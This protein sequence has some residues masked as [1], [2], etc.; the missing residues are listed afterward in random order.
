MTQ[1]KVP[2]NWDNGLLEGLDAA[3]IENAD[4]SLFGMLPSHIAGGGRPSAALKPVEPDTATAY[5]QSA[6][7]LG[8]SFNYLFNA[9]CIDGLEFTKEWRDAFVKHLDWAVES[10]A[11]EITVAIPYILEVAHKR[12]PSLKI[13][14]SS[15]AR[16]HSVQR[17]RHF[18]ELGASEII[19]DPIT[20]ARDFKAIKAIASSVKADCSLI[21]N[22]M[23]LF[24]CPYAEYHAVLMSHSSQKGHISGGKY[25]EYPFYHCTARKLSN[26]AELI[27]SGFIRPED[28][29][30]Y[31]AAGIRRFKLVDRTRPTQWIL[32][33]L[34]AYIARR[35]DGNLLDII[36]FPY[37][38]VSMMWKAAGLSG[39]PVL[40]TIN[41]AAL[42]GFL[43]AIKDIDCRDTDCDVCGLCGRYADR[44]ISSPP[45]VEKTATL[46]INAVRRLNFG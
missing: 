4:I 37:F 29:G 17:A 23:C 33:S 16:V 6:R 13:S 26:A 5:I 38:F 20:M 24:Q 27:R 31:E 46:F 18:E 19:L 25:D 32:R 8:F 39:E 30:A 15:Y 2:C 3:P 21:A 28:I 34:N 42:E 10:G 12:H 35:Y 11:N 14:V 22:G 40:P 36:N 41:N 1:F 44:A 9:A 45:G 7:A 43:D